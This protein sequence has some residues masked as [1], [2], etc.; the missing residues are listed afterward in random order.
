[1][2]C[3][4]SAV[5]GYDEDSEELM[6]SFLHLKALPVLPQGR[7][8]HSRWLALPRGMDFVGP[9]IASHGSL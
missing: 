4:Q 2:T 1:M 3:I 7:P 9:A 8:V 5:M 6:A